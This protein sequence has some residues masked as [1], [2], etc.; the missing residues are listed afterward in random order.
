MWTTQYTKGIITD[1][2]LDD[3]FDNRTRVPLAVLMSPKCTNGLEAF[4]E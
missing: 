1:D 3:V 2:E 4:S